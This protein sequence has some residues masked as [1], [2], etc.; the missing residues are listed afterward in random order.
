MVFSCL[1]ARL[2]A[3]DYYL[4][5]AQRVE[6]IPIDELR[7]H[8]KNPRQGDVG[9]IAESIKT[10]GWYGSL[11]VQTS[12]NEIIA[13]NHRWLAAKSLG[14]TELPV[15]YLDIDSDL[16]LRILIADNR[17]S[18][19]ANNDE[20]ALAKILEQLSLESGLVG[21]GYD[22]DDLEQ[23]LKMLDE[24][25]KFE[26]EAVFSIR[27]SKEMIEKLNIKWDSLGNNTN[28]RIENLLN[29]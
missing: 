23:L 22:N 29:T 14:F 26:D 4:D 21:L 20:S 8:P 24:G 28:D 12:T 10:N 11:I 25:V 1:P 16:A 2:P 17:T 5:M 6:M 13:G 9:A 3:K 7:P 19:L 15:T 27:A 18:D